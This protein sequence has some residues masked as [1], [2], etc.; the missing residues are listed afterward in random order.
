MGGKAVGRRCFKRAEGARA[1]RRASPAKPAPPLPL[2]TAGRRIPTCRRRDARARRAGGLRGGRGGCA[3]GW[4]AGRRRARGVREARGPPPPQQVRVSAARRACAQRPRRGRAGT[5][6]AQGP[7]GW[8]QAVRGRR[9][10][11][12]GSGAAGGKVNQEGEEKPRR[13]P[14]SRE[15]R[16]RGS[17]AALAEHDPPSLTGAVEQVARQ[18]QSQTSETEKKSSVPFAE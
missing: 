3:D 1:A 8:S 14:V 7:C 11:P 5:R 18:Q 17:E 13:M 12:G 6:A 16:S 10:G 9:A 15:R 4:A 2:L